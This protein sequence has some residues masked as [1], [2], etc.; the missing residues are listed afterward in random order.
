MIRSK[1]IKR[2]L[3]EKVA[4]LL[5]QSL[6]ALGYKFKKTSLE[7]SQKKGIGEKLIFL[8]ANY[9]PII[10]DEKSEC[11][12]ICFDL[13][14]R[15]VLTDFEKWY[16]KKIGNE[17]KAGITFMGNYHGY[18]ALD[19][20]DLDKADFYNPTE[21][22]KF[23]QK[24]HLS[25]V[26]HPN[27]Q[28]EKQFFNLETAAT[29]ICDTINQ[30]LD[31]G[32][33]L[34]YLLKA[35]LNVSYNRQA[36]QNFKITPFLLL[37]ANQ[38]EAAKEEAN[39]IYQVYLTELKTLEVHDDKDSAWQFKS[40]RQLF[41][42]FLKDVKQLLGLDFSSPWGAMMRLEANQRHQIKFAPKLFIKEHL[43][44]NMSG[45]ERY[46]YTM[47]HLSELLI[48]CADKAV[49][50]Y[51]KA[52]LLLHQF[53]VPLYNSYPRLG[54]IDA[55]NLFYANHYLINRDG[56]LI[57]LELP[58]KGKKILTK[59]VGA[60]AFDEKQELLYIYYRVSI[61]K[62]VLCSYNNSFKL[63]KSVN[64]S[65][66]I[67]H[68]IPQKNWLV[69]TKG[70]AY[71]FRNLEGDLLFEKPYKK[72]NVYSSFS[73][74]YRYFLSHGYT[75]KTELFDLEN[76]MD[77][78]IWGHPTYLKDYRQIFCHD[79]SKNLGLKNA[80]FAP[81]GKYLLGTAEHGKYVVWMLPDFKRI[82]LIPNQEALDLM[83]DAEVL[84]LH[85]ERMLKNRNNNPFEVFTIEHG[86]YLG[87]RFKDYL[88]L[89]NDRFEHIY[90][91]NA[92]DDFK[93]LNEGYFGV[94]QGDNLVIY[95]K[96]V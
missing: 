73:P 88:W 19:S 24:V 50:L 58:K 81:N 33:G 27:P 9:K 62:G 34:D 70:N 69:L 86:A 8:R 82:E 32:L 21:A 85:G 90:T 20:D 68:C 54:Y 75:T 83:E 7:F 66:A 13:N 42:Q 30:T 56:T 12:Y 71:E 93:P 15:I 37:Q 53:E 11:A 92:I 89:W 22:Q 2:L 55:W 18:L 1:A 6:T 31:N 14:T 79:L 65:G 52:G 10:L 47:N 60:I 96:E 28:I 84:E 77:Q 67:E 87:I 43:R 38:Q 39:R 45:V 29:S 51:N 25:L 59:D 78:I 48:S 46:K 3:K 40:K 26:G 23:K 5:A 49:F 61:R 63:L 94:S 44:F 35:E 64:F 41:D 4:P 57:E 80:Q 76:E 36:H 91:L 95:Q 17:I 72:G 74:D 16:K